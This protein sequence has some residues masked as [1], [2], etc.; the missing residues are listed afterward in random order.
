MWSYIFGA[1]LPPESNLPFASPAEHEAE[2]IKG[3]PE[4]QDQREQA[5]VLE[6]KLKFAI[7]ERKEKLFKAK[8][9]SLCPFPCLSPTSPPPPCTPIPLP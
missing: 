9:G 3:T 6:R 8:R 7:R 1:C 2:T 5:I 4:A